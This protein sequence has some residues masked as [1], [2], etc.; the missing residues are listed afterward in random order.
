MGHARALAQAREIALGVFVS[1]LP[2]FT[3]AFFLGVSENV[4]PKFLTALL[5]PILS[6]F[7]GRHLV[8]S[9]VPWEP[10]RLPWWL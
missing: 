9:L 4:L 6:V 1:Q 7:D 10:R 2:D 8:L 5:L 3:P